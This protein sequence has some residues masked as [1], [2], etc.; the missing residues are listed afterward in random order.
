MT[1]AFLSNAQGSLFACAE[2]PDPASP[3]VMTSASTGDLGINVPILDTCLRV[4][5]PYMTFCST[6]GCLG[7]GAWLCTGVDWLA[8]ASCQAAHAASAPTIDFVSALSTLRREPIA[9]KYGK[10]A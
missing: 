7:E 8:T 3:L 9:P 4:R 2:E 1:P 5:R 10:M 6:S